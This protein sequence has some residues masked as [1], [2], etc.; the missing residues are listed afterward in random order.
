[1][2]SPLVKLTSPMDRRVSGTVV[3]HD[4][5]VWAVSTRGGVVRCP[6]A[7]QGVSIGVTVLVERGTVVGVLPPESEVP[8]FFV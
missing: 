1:M 8:V 2:S 6:S 7:V 3:G 5:G 4:S